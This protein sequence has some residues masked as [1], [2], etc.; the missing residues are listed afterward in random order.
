M[1]FD[2][3]PDELLRDLTRKREQAVE[4]AQQW[5]ALIKWLNMSK[6]TQKEIRQLEEERDEALRQ[7]DEETQR[8]LEAEMKMAEM[9]K[10]SD[11][12]AK[13]TPEAILIKV[14][15]NFVNNSKRKAPEKRSFA[16]S[17]T[18]EIANASGLTLP[19]DL[20]EAIDRLDDIVVEPKIV[21]VAG[22][23]NDVHDNAS[24]TINDGLTEKVG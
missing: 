8:R 20:M 15:R 10:I 11:G 19:P 21:N 12:V 6:A 7:R 16:K 22:N 24:A 4:E 13:N 18:L 3:V 14:L 17:A 5:D 23:Y 9:K 2:E 1:T